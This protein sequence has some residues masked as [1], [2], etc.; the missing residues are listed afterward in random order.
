MT[1][2]SPK[3]LPVDQCGA[4]EAQGLAQRGSWLVCLALLA[5]TLAVYWPVRQFEFLNYDDLDGIVRDPAIRGGLSWP[6][7]VW[8]CQNHHLGNWQPLTS[9]S[10]MLD[11]QW[12]GLRPGPPHL[13]NLAFHLA[14]TLLL[15]LLLQRLTGPRWRSAFVAA[16]FALHPLHVESVAW[17][18]ER[19]DVLSAFFFM[20]TLLAYG[21]WARKSEGRNPKTEG[22]PKTE[23]RM[24]GGTHHV[25]RFTFHAPR[26]TLYALSLLFFALGLMSKP[27]W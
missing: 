11:C 22:S 6:G 18:S 15:F 13:V 23:T 3:A 17:V 1:T 10:H 21:R 8:A 24:T 16:L 14:N 26:S 7:V 27:C 25:S 2:I 5:A 20:L 4:A 19:K 12:F 9:L